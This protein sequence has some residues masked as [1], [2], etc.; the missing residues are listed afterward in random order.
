MSGPKVVRIVTREE[1]LAICEQ[2]L[3]RLDAAIEGWTESGKRANGIN[4]A[5][6]AAVHKRRDELRALLDAN[7]FLDLQKAVPEEIKFLEEDAQARLAAAIERAAAKRTRKRRRCAA[8]NAVIS[9]LR[10]AGK[11]VSTEL[12]SLLEEIAAGNENNADTDRAFADAYAVLAGNSA[13]S[14]AQERTSEIAARLAAGERSTSFAKWR[15]ENLENHED[16]RLKRI[17]NFIVELGSL[18]GPNREIFEQRITAIGAEPSQTRK[19]LLTD[20]LVA[21][22]ADA[23]RVARENNYLVAKLREQ[24]AE[25]RRFNSEAARALAANLKTAI[26]ASNAAQ[27][28]ELIASAKVL[29][30]SEINRLAA[31]ARRKAILQGLSSLGYEVQEGMATAFAKGDAVV[32]RHANT[33][34]FGLEINGSPEAE[35]LQMR[36]VAFAPQGVPR[37]RSR[38]RDVEVQWCGD[39]DK[40]RGFLGSVG[41]DIAIERSTVAGAIPLKV[42]SEDR[43]DRDAGDQVAYPSQL[44]ARQLP[45]R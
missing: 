5:D 30:T 29:V 12:L 33:P 9:K 21:D 24:L 6:I 14:V 42:I 38:D 25:V 40:L 10:T 15:V 32:M 44:K 34:G 20:S 27:A 26:T 13:T 4:E 7:A 37:D 23:T 45:S 18:G 1:I 31:E 3:A 43:T 39:L 19:R 17:D 11:D 28:N 41:G 36:I 2:H 16:E 8:A 35:R 22:L